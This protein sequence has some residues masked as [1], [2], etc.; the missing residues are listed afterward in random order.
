MARRKIEL[1]EMK[2]DNVLFHFLP[3]K[4][5]MMSEALALVRFFKIKINTEHTPLFH[6]CRCK[7]QNHVLNHNI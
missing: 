2:E 5:A 3:Q 7:L 1:K 4:T 6:E